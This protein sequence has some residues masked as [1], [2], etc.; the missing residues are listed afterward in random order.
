MF[1]SHGEF[2]ILQP[3]GFSVLS[4]HGHCCSHL[5]I[6][7]DQMML[8]ELDWQHKKSES[9]WNDILW[10]CHSFLFTVWTVSVSKFSASLLFIVMVSHFS[11]HV[12]MCVCFN[13][14]TLS[15]AMYEAVTTTSTLSLRSEMNSSTWKQLL[16][17]IFQLDIMKWKSVPKVS[18][19]RFMGSVDTSEG[20]WDDH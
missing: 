15:V 7:E 18:V 10:W 1:E 4:P 20:F 16:C 17:C 6:T 8:H 5:V 19:W 14:I 12:R 2:V 11:V 9:Y 13:T 3:L